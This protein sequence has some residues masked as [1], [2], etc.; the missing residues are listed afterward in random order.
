MRSWRDDL[1]LSALRS[2]SSCLSI[3][4]LHHW[5]RLFLPF[6]FPFPTP[7]PEEWMTSSHVAAKN[8]L[9]CVSYPPT[10]QLYASLPVHTVSHSLSLPLLSISSNTN[11]L[12]SFCPQLLRRFSRCNLAAVSAYLPY[13][14][15]C[16]LPPLS[17]TYPIRLF[18]FLCLA[19]SEFVRRLSTTF[20]LRLLS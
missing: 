4:T 20:V 17:S 19:V 3:T 11:Y 8:P 15:F 9:H 10:I 14:T 16:S 2:S 13:Q 1:R 6:F 18:P 7:S 12:C 5:Y